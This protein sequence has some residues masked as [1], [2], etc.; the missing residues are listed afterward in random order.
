VLF[1]SVIAF[2]GWAVVLLAIGIRAV[3]GWDWLRSVATL[4]LTAAPIV[5]LALVHEFL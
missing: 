1:W 3:H 2:G 4:A 5:L